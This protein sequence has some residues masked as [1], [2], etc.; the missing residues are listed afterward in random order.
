MKVWVTV[1]HPVVVVPSPK[2]QVQFEEFV[3]VLAKLT[4][5][6]AHPEVTSGTNE[7]AG[8]VS[9]TTTAVPDKGCIQ[10]GAVLETIPV[11]AYVAVVVSA[12]VFT[13][14]VPEALSITVWLAP[15]LIV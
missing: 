4:V 9:T 6:G 7:I 10:N 2:F 14:A 13:V 12:A 3:V 5:N 15:P 11:R 1:P 8:G